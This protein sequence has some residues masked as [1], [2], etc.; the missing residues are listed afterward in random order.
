MDFGA[1]NLNAQAVPP[2]IAQASIL[3]FQASAIQL[4]S[5]FPSKS[6]SEIDA[7]M[8]LTP[9][10]GINDDGTVFSL[11][12]AQTIANFAKLNSIG[13]LS[14]WSFQRDIAQSTSGMGPVGT[15]SGVAQSNY[16][17]YNIFQSAGVYTPPPAS[18]PAPASA[19]NIVLLSNGQLYVAKFANPGYDPTTSTY[20]WAPYGC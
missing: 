17:F 20:Y 11:D 8:G 4:A 18:L 1:S 6:K 9:M 5:V 15:Y 3:N 2:T 16:Q 10:I 19:C 13:L 14:Y 7:M 12:Q